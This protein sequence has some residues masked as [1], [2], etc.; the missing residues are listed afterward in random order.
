MHQI[1]SQLPAVLLS[2]LYAAA[3][4]VALSD[5]PH[6][7]LAGLVVLGG[8]VVRRLRQRRRSAVA[9][10]VAAEPEPVP[11]PGLAAPS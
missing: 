1:R 2:L 6:R 5:P 8:L 10:P 7:G 11:M 4:A 9:H 3:L